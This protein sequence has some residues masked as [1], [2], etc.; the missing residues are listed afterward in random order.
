[1]AKSRK[2]RADL[3]KNRSSRRRTGNLTRA[4]AADPDHASDMA[5]SERISGKGDLTRKRTVII[6]DESSTT[7]DGLSVSPIAGTTWCGQVMQVHGL[8]SFVR[9][10]DGRIVRCTT[11]RLLRTLSTEQRHPVAAGDWVRIRDDSG[12]GVIQSIE[13]R[14]NSLCRAS[15]GRRHVI[16]AN[17]DQVVIVGSAAMPDLKPALLDRLLVAAESAG[18]RPIICINKIDLVD[19]SRLVPLAGVFSRMGYATVLCSAVSGVGIARLRHEL[20]GRVTAIVGQSGVGKSSLLNAIDPQLSLRVGEVSRENEKG[21]HTTT[22]ARLIPHA[23]NSQTGGSF[24]DTPGVRQF[25]LWEIVPAE[26]PAAF[27]D[28]RPLANLC[29]FPD[30]SHTHE[31]D[32]VVKHAVADGLLDTRR[33]E[34]C[35]HL[36]ATAGAEDADAMGDPDSDEDYE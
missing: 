20:G 7:G 19:A 27:R 34:S 15:R 23:L 24:V 9:A 22:T 31:V 14:R 30:C 12:V 16:V 18:I 29:R 21:R 36:A 1:M 33:W 6:H 11:R 28:L 3:R 2:F 26:V 35:C 13:P 25:Q 32:C 4:V 5:S 8:E 17:V 10:G